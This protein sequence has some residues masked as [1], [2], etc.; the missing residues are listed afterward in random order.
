MRRSVILAAMVRGDGRATAR[1]TYFKAMSA[2]TCPCHDGSAMQHP[3][4]C[5]DDVG[6]IHVRSA[7]GLDRPQHLSFR[8]TDFLPRHGDVLVDRIAQCGVCSVHSASSSAL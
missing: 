8:F 5:C 2:A 7:V 3:Y 4:G 6:A 1:A